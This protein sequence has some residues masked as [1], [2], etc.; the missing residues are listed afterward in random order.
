MDVPNNR[1][2]KFATF[3][4]DLDAAQ[5]ENAQGP[6]AAEPQVFDL[7]ALLCRNPKRLITHDE[8]IEKVWH[9][10]IVSDSAIATRMNAARKVLGDDGSAQKIIKTIRGRGFRMELMPISDGTGTG[11]KNEDSDQSDTG[12]FVLSCTPHGFALLM[13]TRS[14]Q[15]SLDWHEKLPV[16]LCDISKQHEGII[17]GTNIAVF[18]NGIDA[19]NCAAALI[20]AVKQQ[21]ADL[22]GEQRWT[23][24][25]GIAFGTV[26]HGFAYALAARLDAAALPGGLCIT[27]RVME[28]ITDKIEIDTETNSNNDPQDSHLPINVT[29]IGAM[30]IATSIEDKPAQVAHLEIPQSGEISIIVLPIE[31][32]DKPEQLAQVAL[33]LRLEIQ[34]ALAQLSGILPM[35]AGT[36]NAFVGTTSP[37]VA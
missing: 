2:L 13:A 33:G 8:I 26:N 24:K 28:L 22:P 29:R 1:V 16:L 23:L 31:C 14:G 35:A 3:S 19:M 32:A 34:N 12:K 11:N 10:R 25:L 21:C 20:A 17:A 15:A 36:A 9:G 6:I 4:V 30:Q 5:V 27:R 18:D 37:N 7:I